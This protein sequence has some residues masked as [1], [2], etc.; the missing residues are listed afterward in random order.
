[1]ICRVCEDSGWVCE[2]GRP[3]L[4]GSRDFQKKQL[5]RHD[6]RAVS[7]EIASGK[8][9][10]FWNDLEAYQASF[11]AKRPNVETNRSN[12][13]TIKQRSYLAG[14]Q[15]W[16]CYP[17]TGLDVAHPETPRAAQISL[18]GKPCKSCKRAYA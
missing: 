14:R 8:R 10:G 17:G 2:H 15:R 3:P 1:M 4:R 9:E 12:A 5:L 7:E 13:D 11:A 6:S 16:Q 18:V